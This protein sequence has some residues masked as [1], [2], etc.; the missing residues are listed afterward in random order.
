MI[1][2]II[3]AGSGGQGI[4][5]LGKILATAALKKGENVTWFPTYGAEVRGGTAHCMVVVSSSDI[6]S[7]YIDKADT[8]I[9]MNDLS[10]SKFKQRLKTKGLLLANSS[11]ADSNTLT[12]ICANPTQMVADKKSA[13]ICALPFTEVAVNL[14]N[15]KVANMVALGA[16]IAKKK[17]ITKQIAFATIEDIAPA[18]KKNLIAINKQAIEEGIRLIG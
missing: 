18:E 8:L 6:P 4:L 7:P 15:I 14:G 9:I 10:L 16:Y 12:Q 2:K 5:L 1:E 3:I 13:C 11:L 17:I